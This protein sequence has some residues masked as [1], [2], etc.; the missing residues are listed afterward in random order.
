MLVLALTIVNLTLLGSLGAALF[1]S[2]HQRGQ[3]G[4]L[5]NLVGDH[6]ADQFLLNEVKQELAETK[7]QL[8][9]SRANKP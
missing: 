7:M 2:R 3:I 1:H 5:T 8:E 4:E 9:I 6:V